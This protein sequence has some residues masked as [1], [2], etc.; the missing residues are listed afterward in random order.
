MRAGVIAKTACRSCRLVYKKIGGSINLQALSEVFSGLEGVSILGGNEAESTANRFS[1]WASEPLEIFEFK[2]GEEKPFEKLEHALAKYK[3][4]DGNSNEISE[5]I[6]CGGWVGYFSYELGRYIE[7]L[8]ETMV[9]DLQMPLIRLGF[10]DRV[11]CYDHEEKEF[12]LIVLEL[13]GDSES[14]EEK[15]SGLERLLEDAGNINMP[16]PVKGNLDDIEFSQIKSNMERGYYLDA[17]EKIRHYIYDGQVYQ[18][19]FSQRFE[20]DYDADSIKLYH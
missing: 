7:K 1:Y 11:I 10:Y 8:P 6:F 16:L 2:A 19:N 5:G 3:L 20:C 18:V 13:E 9:D 4:E 17:I 14:A 12:R 15:I